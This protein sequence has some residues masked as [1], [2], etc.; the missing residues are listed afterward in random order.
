MLDAIHAHPRATPR[1]DLLPQR[2]DK[3]H[4][5]R[6]RICVEQG[7][8][9]IRP[10][11]EKVQHFHRCGADLTPVLLKAEVWRRRRC[12]TTEAITEVRGATPPIQI[13]CNNRGF[14]ENP[15]G[16]YGQTIS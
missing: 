15:D 8:I 16:L 1:L 6:R 7:F 3:I 13:S 2:F 9:A 5:A 11:C 10:H 14:M 4:H 12:C